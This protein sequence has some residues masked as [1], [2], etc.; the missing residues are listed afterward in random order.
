VQTLN[1]V[2]AHRLWSETDRRVDSL[3][4]QV[5]EGRGVDEASNFARWIEFS[6]ILQLLKDCSVELPLRVDGH[7]L[8]QK[9][10]SLNNACGEWYSLHE[11]SFKPRD[12]YIPQSKLE[13]IE[14]R[15]KAIED[16]LSRMDNKFCSPP[17]MDTAEMG[18]SSV[19]VLHVIRGG[20][21]A[22]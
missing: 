16:N 15:L 1:P 14:A 19:P 22:S 7:G 12:S 21:D 18:A 2:Q 3:L 6:G 10:T 20:R 4:K 13:S 9:I 8:H 5:A 17:S 11:R